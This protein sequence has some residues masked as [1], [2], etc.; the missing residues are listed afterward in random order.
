MFV[1]CVRACVSACVSAC[2]RACVSACVSACVRA[3]V[4][5]CASR[6]LY[7]LQFTTKFMGHM[8]V[9]RVLVIYYSFTAISYTPCS[10]R[11]T[12]YG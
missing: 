1:A 5:A 9:I 10:G 11:M 8:W 4:R 2:V 12:N 7:I 6:N 3:C